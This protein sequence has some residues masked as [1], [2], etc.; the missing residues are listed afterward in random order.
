MKN[1]Q[2]AIFFFEKAAM[3]PQYK[4]KTA[5]TTP[6]TGGWRYRRD[7]KMDLGNIRFEFNFVPYFWNE[8]ENGMIW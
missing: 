6:D 7:G 3:E 8:F 5:T 4:Y 2:R 1:G